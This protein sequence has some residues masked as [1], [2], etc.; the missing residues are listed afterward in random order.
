[1]LKRVRFSRSDTQLED[2]EGK[3]RFDTEIL[4][5]LRRDW[6]GVDST[7]RI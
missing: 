2:E 7:T 3:P 1:M 4:S 5:P 6:N